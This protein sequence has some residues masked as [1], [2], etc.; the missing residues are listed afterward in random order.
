MGGVSPNEP[1]MG[2]GIGVRRNV[3]SRVGRVVGEAGSVIWKLTRGV[4]VVNAAESAVGTGP[5]WLP[6]RRGVAPP[7]LNGSSRAEN[8][9]L[10]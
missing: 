3:P 2:D 7:A 6:A 4:E 1:G 5:G 10:A 8:R 9:R